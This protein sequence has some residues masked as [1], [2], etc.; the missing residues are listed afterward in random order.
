[1]TETKAQLLNKDTTKMNKAEMQEHI[2]KISVAFNQAQRNAKI[3]TQIRTDS[4]NS[5]M[6]ISVVASLN[7]DLRVS[8]F[9]KEE[10]IITETNTKNVTKDV[11]II[12][13]TDDFKT[14]CIK[15]ISEMIKR[16][17]KV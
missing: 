6:H 7:D 15:A 4:L 2:N 8:T 9:F 10:K 1:M 11:N 3:E 14:E 12:R 5:H 13:V 17:K 16:N